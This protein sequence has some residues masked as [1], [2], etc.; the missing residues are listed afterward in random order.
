VPTLSSSISG[1]LYSGFALTNEEPLKPEYKTP[2][3][4][5]LSVGTVRRACEFCH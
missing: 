4:E 2:E 3:I 1:V 5:L